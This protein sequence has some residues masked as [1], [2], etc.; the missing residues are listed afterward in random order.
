MEQG[1]V[2]GKSSAVSMNTGLEPGPGQGQAQGQGFIPVPTPVSTIGKGKGA[3]TSSS[4]S[5]S[6]SSASSGGVDVIPLIAAAAEKCGI[7]DDLPYDL[8][9]ADP[10][11][12]ATATG[13]T[14]T[15]ATTATAGA[16]TTPGADAAPGSGLGVNKPPR[17]KLSAERASELLAG[18]QADAFAKEFNVYAGALRVYLSELERRL[19]SEGGLSRL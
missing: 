5:S 15:T 2:P 11:P 9:F 18:P 14:A 12:T 3:S 4:S 13:A 19:F 1:A 16:T 10:L 17:G 8:S 7:Y 6:S